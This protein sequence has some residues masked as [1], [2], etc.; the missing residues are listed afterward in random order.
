MNIRIGNGFDV[1]ALATGRRLVLGGVT[2][3]GERG[4]AHEL[5]L[6]DAAFAS[7]A[8][9]V[10]D[11]DGHV[12]AIELVVSQIDRAVGP[13]TQLPLDL[14]FA[15]PLQHRAPQ[16]I[17]RQF[18]LAACRPGAYGAEPPVRGF[19]GAAGACAKLKMENRR[20]RCCSTP[21]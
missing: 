16:S 10:V 18:I 8:G 15:Y 5:D 2:I 19:P 20:A 9:V 14:I 4:L 6:E 3:P 17:R 11:L 13:L 1:H 7:P 21:R 12:R